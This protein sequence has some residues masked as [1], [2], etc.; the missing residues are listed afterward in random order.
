M[1]P[2]FSFGLF[3][4]LDKIYVEGLVHVTALKHDYYQFDPVGQKLQGER[5]GKTY[6]LANK[7]RAQVARVDLDEKKIDFELV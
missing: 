6:R 1:S 5:S 2:E 4:A 7:I 3:V